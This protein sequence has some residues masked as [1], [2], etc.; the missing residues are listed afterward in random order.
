MKFVDSF[1]D[2]DSLK[3]QDKDLVQK[4]RDNQS[5][6]RRL[7]LELLGLEETKKALLNEERKLKNLE[8]EKAGDLVK[9]QAALIRERELRQNLITDLKSLIETYRQILKDDSTFQNFEKLSDS[10]IIVG[11]DYFKKV[12]DIVAQF[13]KIV[14]EKSGELNTALN[15]KIDELNAELRKWK[16]EEQKIQQEIDKKKKELEAQGIPFDLGKINQISKDI[17]DLSTKVKTLEGYQ[18]NLK[19]LEE[20]RKELLDARLSVKSK[21]YY[22]RQEFARTV[23]QNLKNTIDGLFITVKYE[24]GRYSEDFEKL[25]KTTMD[26]R[27]SQVPKATLLARALSPLEFVG[28]CKKNEQSKL[29]NL[30][31]PDGS[32]FLSP[33]DVQSIIMRLHKDFCYEEF[34][35]IEYEDRPNIYVTREYIDGNGDKQRNTKPISFLSLGQQ[36]SILLGILLLSKSN[37][38]LIIDQPEDNLDSEFI[39][40]TIVKNLRKV[41]EYRQVIIVTHNPNIAVL[42]DAELIIPLKSTSS[43]SH[44][45]HAGSIDRGE[46]RE[47]CCEILE[48]GKS[49]FNQ[50]KEIY[51]I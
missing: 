26:W 34:E 25:I 9:Y 1:L 4:L 39:F 49:A 46:T 5:R 14:S 16:D 29:R 47:I 10:E 36:Q 42:G 30:T 7:R 37:K 2:L 38:P 45:I 13:S 6:S 23:N 24:E 44:V 12:K 51:G 15:S 40:K 20:S 35:S 28:I 27:T 32:K 3:K 50:R 17:I 22:I 33:D 31:A 19:E 8:K 21:I 11:K 18:K 43:K 41:K 48:G